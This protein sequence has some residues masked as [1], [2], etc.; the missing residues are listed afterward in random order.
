MGRTTDNT[1]KKMSGKPHLCKF[2]ALG[3]ISISPN[4]KLLG[5]F[6][7]DRRVCTATQSLNGRTVGTCC[8]LHCVCITML[9]STSLWF[10]T[11]AG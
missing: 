5:L 2:E 10:G 4:G 7:Q 3:E 6:P 11:Q 9:F 8:P 1:L